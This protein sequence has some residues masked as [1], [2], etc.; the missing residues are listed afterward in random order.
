MLEDG[1][2]YRRALW[3]GIGRDEVFIICID[4]LRASFKKKNW[5]YR[6]QRLR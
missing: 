1:D 4:W 2:E 6:G 3:S 5:H